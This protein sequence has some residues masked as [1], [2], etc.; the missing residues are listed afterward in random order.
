MIGG[1]SNWPCK[2]VAVN[3]IEPATPGISLMEARC[4]YRFC[5]L[6][7]T[8]MYVCV[9]TSD[10][11]RDGVP[12]QR[13]CVHVLY[14]IV[15][16]GHPSACTCFLSFFP[17][18]YNIHVLTRLTISPGLRGGI[19]NQTEI[20]MPS[21]HI[22]PRSGKRKTHIFIGTSHAGCKK[23]R[24]AP[25]SRVIPHCTAPYR[26]VPPLQPRYIFILFLLGPLPRCPAAPC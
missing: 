15:T 24:N 12:L 11:I 7:R 3:P 21:A 18:M 17:H 10:S 2:E 8:Y 26:T 20:Y 9:Y 16:Q 22:Q 19:V 5:Q 4:G 25:R 1:E 13:E 23:K 14:I 6:L